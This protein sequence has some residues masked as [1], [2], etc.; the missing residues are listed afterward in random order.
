MEEIST[1]TQG[2]TEQFTIIVNGRKKVVTTD[3]LSYEQVV[4]LAYDNNPPTGPNIV[5]SVTYRNAEDNKQGTL[6][7]GQTV[8]IRNGTIFNVTATDK[9]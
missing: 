8:E 3:E 9:S 4:A 6:V 7:A 2:Q 1:R 5:I